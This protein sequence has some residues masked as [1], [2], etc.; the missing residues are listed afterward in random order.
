M[1]KSSEFLAAIH[2]AIAMTLPTEAEQYMMRMLLRLRRSEFVGAYSE[3]KRSRLIFI[4]MHS[5]K[6]DEKYVEMFDGA[7]EDWQPG[8]KIA[9]DLEYRSEPGAMLDPLIHG[10]VVRN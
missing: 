3:P 6:G 4:A 1:S 10:I 9:L 7:L 8:Y 5:P 2:D